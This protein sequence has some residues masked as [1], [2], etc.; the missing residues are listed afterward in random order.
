MFSRVLPALLLSWKS[1]HC[2]I[3]YSG[4]IKF[5]VRFHG[6]DMSNLPDRPW[7]EE[8]KVGFQVTFPKMSLD[9]D[10]TL[11]FPTQRDSQEGRNSVELSCPH[12]K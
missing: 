10:G 12:H 6:L 4:E 7:T 9:I 3:E 1:R 5:A 2:D 8:E 11:V